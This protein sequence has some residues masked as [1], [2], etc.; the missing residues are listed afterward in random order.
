MNVLSRITRRQLAGNRTRTAVTVI[1]IILS[2]AMITAVTTLMASLYDYGVRAAKDIRG[3]WYAKLGAANSAVVQKLAADERVED[4]FF[5]RYDGCELTDPTM[6]AKTPLIAVSAVSPEFFDNMGIALTAGRLPENGTEVVLPNSDEAE[7]G[8]EVTVELGERMRHG[9]PLYRTDSLSVKET[10]EPGEKRTYTVV[11]IYTP[12]RAEEN[13]GPCYNYLTVIEGDP[14][15]GAN[16]GG[17]RADA[18][19]RTYKPM[20]ATAVYDEITAPVVNKE[21]GVILN[22]S[23][24]NGDLFQYLDVSQL[25]KN[26]FSLYSARSCLSLLPRD[27]CL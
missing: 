14:V 19:I 24:I 25:V 9:A 20:D 1:G 13:S 18:F 17:R 10:W 3:N 16:A 5:M 21:A 8:T 23:Y 12:N 2:V 7:I 27:R 6:T 15:A 22:D 26:A 4:I 11:G